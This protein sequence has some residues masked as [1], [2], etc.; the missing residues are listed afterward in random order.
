V[1][2]NGYIITMPRVNLMSAKVVAGSKDADL[3]ADFELQAFSDDANA[4]AGL[5]KTIFIDRVGVALAPLV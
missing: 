3:M 2:G 1:A 4:V 5:R